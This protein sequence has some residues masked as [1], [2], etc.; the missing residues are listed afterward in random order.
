[1]LLHNDTYLSYKPDAISRGTYSVQGFQLY[2][3]KGWHVHHGTLKKDSCSL[4]RHLLTSVC[5]LVTCNKTSGT[6]LPWETSIGVCDYDLSISSYTSLKT[7]TGK[8]VE[9]TETE[10]YPLLPIDV[11]IGTRECKVD[12]WQC[13][14]TGPDQIICNA[15]TFFVFSTD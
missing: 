13:T 6:T 9:K 3:I 10:L 7:Q 2:V 11:A 15:A 4:A 8:L 1:M 5:S 12:K 14:V